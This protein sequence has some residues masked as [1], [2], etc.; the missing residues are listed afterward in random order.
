MAKQRVAA[1]ARPSPGTERPPP[2]PARSSLC[3]KKPAAREAGR[4]R[5]LRAEPKRENSS[6]KKAAAKGDVQLVASSGEEDVGK[7]RRKLE[8]Q[9]RKEQRDMV[10]EKL[11][12]E[13]MEGPPGI[14]APQHLPLRLLMRHRS[15]AWQ[16]RVRGKLSYAI[17][18]G[19]ER[20]LSP[21][22]SE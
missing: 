1:D 11:V 17:P 5:R 12:G 2:S 9:K 6:G 14:V 21:F 19:A 16:W 20:P 10:M 13:L 3:G 15:V 7:K 4:P 18:I 8:M 22:S